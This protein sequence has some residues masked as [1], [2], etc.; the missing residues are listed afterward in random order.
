MRIIVYGIG[1]YDPTKPND[2]II[3]EYDV[4]D[5]VPEKISMRQCRLV[6]LQQ[7]LLN[8]VQA[9]IDTAGNE[10]YKIEWEYA[11]EVYRNAALVQIIAQ[12]LPLTEEQVDEL[13]VLAATL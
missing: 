11:S 2:N 1:G 6:L 5:I 10:A 13:F 9:L 7:N 8:D 4:P 3:E 12:E